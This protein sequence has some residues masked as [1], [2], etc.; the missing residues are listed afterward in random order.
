MPWQNS[1]DRAD[2]E[3][4]QRAKCPKCGHEKRKKCDGQGWIAGNDYADGSSMTDRPCPNDNPHYE[5][6]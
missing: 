2:E 1:F 5:T 3:R 4:R 6:H